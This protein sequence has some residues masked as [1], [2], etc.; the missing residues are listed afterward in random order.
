MGYTIRL[1]FKKGKSNKL[2]YFLNAPC[3][4]EKKFDIKLRELVGDFGISKEIDFSRL[5]SLLDNTLKE[6]ILSANTDYVRTNYFNEFCNEMLN[7][8]PS[9]TKLTA[10]CSNNVE[11]IENPIDESFPTVALW[12]RM[13]VN[14]MVVFDTYNL[15]EA[16]DNS[17][18]LGISDK[19]M[20]KFPVLKGGI[21][22]FV[23]AS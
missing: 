18:L 13:T 6:S 20:W 11:N 1:T 17:K 15:I 21:K 2:V 7:M 3:Y 8:T 10:K 9:F 22:C 19:N 14:T 5:F 12:L 16:L 4:Y 23:S